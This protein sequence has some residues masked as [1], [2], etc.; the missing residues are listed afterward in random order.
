MTQAPSVNIQQDPA[1]NASE[2][3]KSMARPGIRQT[4]CNSASPFSR[5]ASH[6]LTSYRLDATSDAGH[7]LGS[8]TSVYHKLLS[9]LEIGRENQA[10]NRDWNNL[11]QHKQSKAI[12]LPVRS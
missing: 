3:N 12:A 9:E 4:S 7:T 10:G 5:Q 11:D 6:Q 8:V 1:A 2:L